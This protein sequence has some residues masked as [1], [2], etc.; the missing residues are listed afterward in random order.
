MFLMSMR[1]MQVM[2]NYDGMNKLVGMSNITL[3]KTIFLPFS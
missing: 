3:G 2:K 1:L